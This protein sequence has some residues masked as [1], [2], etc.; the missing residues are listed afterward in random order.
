[1]II[2]QENHFGQ[3]VFYPQLP[4]SLPGSPSSPGGKTLSSRETHKVCFWM[5]REWG[6]NGPGHSRSLLLS[7]NRHTRL[8]QAK[9]SAWGELGGEGV[10]LSQ[11]ALPSSGISYP[12]SAPRVHTPR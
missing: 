10:P 2:P 6:D 3:P 12:N 9:G 1:M 4:S 5:V 8:G 7:L 11:E